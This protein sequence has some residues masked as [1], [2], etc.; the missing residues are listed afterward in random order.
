MIHGWD[1]DTG[2]SLAEAGQRVGL[3]VFGMQRGGRR[4]EEEEE[5]DWLD[6]NSQRRTAQ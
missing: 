2:N 5:K 3:T 4:D 6:A 1:K